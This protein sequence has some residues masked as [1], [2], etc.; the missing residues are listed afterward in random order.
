[1]KDHI[2]REGEVIFR[3]GEPSDAVLQI[4]SGEV[5]VFRDLGPEGVTLGRVGPGEFLGE[6]GVLLDAPHSA[7]ARAVGKVEAVRF[8][9]EQ[10]LSRL[11]GDRESSAALIVRL[12][13]RLRIANRRLSRLGEAEQVSTPTPIPG[14][15]VAIEAPATRREKSEVVVG[16]PTVTFFA[17]SPRLAGEMPAA[18]VVADSFPFTVGRASRRGSR[19]DSRRANLTFQDERPY[20]LSRSHFVIERSGTDVVVRDLGSSLGTAVNGDYLGQ[21]FGRDREV[22]KA[23]ENTVRAGG[24]ASPFCWK[25]VVTPRAGGADVP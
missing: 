14:S 9:R 5:E 15:R 3:E 7:S 11:G 4:V 22:L 12:C 18:G 25:V 21:A 6:M 17:N 20:R 23:G 24:D 1:M 16:A 10:F 19:G 8:E 13:E 2:Y